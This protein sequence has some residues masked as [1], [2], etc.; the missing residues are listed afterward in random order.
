MR[1]VVH[2]IENNATFIWATGLFLAYFPLCFMGPGSDDDSLLIIRTAREWVTT[3]R[4]FGW[5]LNP[6]YWV[7]D[8]IALVIGSV[9]GITLMNIITSIVTIVGA[10]FLYR[11]LQEDDIP[12]PRLWATVY[13]LHPIVW[14]N[15]TCLID[16]NWALTGILMGIWAFQNCRFATA[17][18]GLA[19]A[20]GI[21]LSSF[22]V[23]PILIITHGVQRA[24]GWR[25]KITMALIGWGIGGLFYV[26]RFMDM[27]FGFLMVNST[28]NGDWSLASYIGRFVYK[29]IYFWGLPQLAI[30]SGLLLA[31]LKRKPS[32]KAPSPHIKSMIGISIAMIIIFHSLFARYPFE[33]EYLLPCFP[34]AIYLIARTFGTKKNLAIAGASVILSYNFISINVLRPDKPNGASTVTAGVWTEPGYLI[35]DTLARRKVKTVTIPHKIT[36]E[37]CLKWAQNGHN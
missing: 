11:I 8:T 13:A 2:A 15:A 22:F 17:I 16:Y 12:F 4:Y 20:T 23:F 24:N 36:M 37:K 5:R 25:K 18:G 28:W 26:A 10:F 6:G 33:N 3:G 34:F 1:R 29:S 19:F 14:V 32:E 21:R 9:G 31:S 7:H 35:Q 30:L 27:G